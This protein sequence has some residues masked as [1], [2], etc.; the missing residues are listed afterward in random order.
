MH[1]RRG[2]AKCL[3]GRVDNPVNTNTF[4]GLLLTVQCPF[5]II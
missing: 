5:C 1:G 2:G 4:V 3:G